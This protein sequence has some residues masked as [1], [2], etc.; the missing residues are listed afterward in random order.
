ME[1]VEKMPGLVDVAAAAG[2]SLSTVSRVIT[3]R[4]PVSE[5]TR[6]RVMDAV[7]RLGYRP[8]AAA[9]ALVSGR[10][11]TVAVIAKNTLRWG[12]A[13]TLQGIEE[14]ARAAGYTVMIAVVES[15]E[16][17]ELGRATDLVWSQSLAGAIVIDFDA[18]GS[19][20]MA[21]LPHNVPVVAA[22]GARSDGMG[23]PHAFLD[24]LEGGRAATEYLLSLGHETVHHVAIPATSE[25]S[26]R[27]WG[28]QQALTAAGSPIPPIIRASYHPES[29]YEAARELP[30]DATAVLCGNDELAIGVA[31]FLQESGRR[32]PFDV[33][34]MGFDDQPFAAM[35]VPALSTVRQDFVDLGRRTFRL[36]EQWIHGGEV[37][38]DS[39]ASPRLVIR[40]STSTPPQATP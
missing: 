35:W 24:D 40:E 30:S 37:P 33:S 21:A 6:T 14:E 23:R 32:V 27:E 8:N 18:V 29:G 20:T 39:T 1:A 31:R 4:T 17:E 11:S 38:P 3:G 15:S 10:S 7:E 26:G 22:S 19:A 9:Q 13:A 16:P 34:I 28:W 12:Y 36:L 5:R 25:H 2:V